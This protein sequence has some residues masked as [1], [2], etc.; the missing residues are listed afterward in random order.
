MIVELEYS[1]IFVAVVIF[2]ATPSEAQDDRSLP[3]VLLGHY[4][5]YLGEVVAL[6]MEYRA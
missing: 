5:W 2:R 4:Q 6:G 3:I 1:G